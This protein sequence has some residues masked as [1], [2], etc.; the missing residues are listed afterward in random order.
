MCALLHREAGPVH[1]VFEDPRAL[2]MLP[3]Y[4]RRW[5]QMMVIPKAHVTSYREVE[6]TTWAY[7]NQLAHTAAQVVEHVQKPRLCYVA[8]IGSN[9]VVKELAQSSRHLHIH[10]IPVYQAQDRPAD[11]FSWAEGVYVADP[12]EWEALRQQYQDAWQALAPELAKQ[13][14]YSGPTKATPTGS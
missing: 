8:S 10:V 1:A 6:A 13:P 12:P 11:I 5:G 3:R 14:D 2:V 4:V 9:P 7:A